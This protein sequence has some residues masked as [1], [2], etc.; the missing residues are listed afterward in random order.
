MNAATATAAAL[1][2]ADLLT[3]AATVAA[4]RADL[5]PF[6]A[7][8]EGLRAGAQRAHSLAQA[9][10]RG[11]DLGLER[12]TD[13]VREIDADYADGGEHA[14]PAQAD[15]LIAAFTA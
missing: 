12:F 8:K 2:A 11:M 13:A 9:L 1:H 5:L 14:L 15:K 3:G 10:Q 7:A 6:G 4:A